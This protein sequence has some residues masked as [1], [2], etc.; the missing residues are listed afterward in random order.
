MMIIPNKLN[1]LVSCEFSANVR[2]ELRSLGINAW[3]CDV[4]P[5]EG[6]PQWHIQGNVVKYL[7]LG[8]DL[9]IAHPPCK[10]LCNSGLRWLYLGGRKII[11]PS[12]EPN[13][14]YDRCEAMHQAAE[15]YN[16][17]VNAP[18][19]LIAVENSRMHA[20]AITECGEPDQSVQLW[21]F[22][23]P[24]T[25][26][27]CFKLKGLPKL[28]PTLI[29]PP[30]QRQALVHREPPGPERDKN[31]SRTQPGIAAAMATQWGGFALDRHKVRHE[32]T[33]QGERITK[34]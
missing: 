32:P 26:E 31:R 5:T 30:P 1:A 22:G 23:D 2:D 7:N 9:M 16:T 21:Q 17:H 15:F 27:H 11:L 19:P 18:I 6:D 4:R 34:S 8:W 14:D 33:S 25:K 29:I 20:Y 28:R 13:W 12:G 24:E 10:Y 3:S